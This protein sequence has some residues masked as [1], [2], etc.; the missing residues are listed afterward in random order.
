MKV[1]E[2]MM[3]LFYAG[4]LAKVGKVTE[5]KFDFD[6]VNGAWH[7]WFHFAD[8][9]MTHNGPRGDEP[10]VAVITSVTQPPDDVSG[11]SEIINW[12]LAN[13]SSE[14]LEP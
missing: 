4:T 14:R 1:T 8:Q 2:G 11:Y 7:G 5:N 12:M 6:C 9:T 10:D 3:I 13:P